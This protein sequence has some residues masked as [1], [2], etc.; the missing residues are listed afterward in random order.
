MGTAIKDTRVIITGGANGLGFMYSRHMLLKGA[1]AVAILDIDVATG[2]NAVKKLNDEFGQNRAVFISTD[3]SKDDQLKASFNKA[4]EHLGGLDIMINNAGIL[5]D[6]KWSL[7][8][9]INIKA[10]I[11][12]TYMAIETMGKHKGGKGGTIIN[13]GSVAAF[14]LTKY[15][16][17][18]CA[19]KSAVVSF[20]RSV[21]LSF[22]DVGVNIKAMCPG[23]TNTNLMT[24][25]AYRF[26]EYIDQEDGVKFMNAWPLQKPEIMAKEV[27]RFI[28]EAPNGAIW[29]NEIDSPTTC[30]DI[31]E[32]TSWKTPV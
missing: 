20:T 32:Y 31:P 1:K 17:V 3:V 13:I 8:I 7:M 19:T 22:D 27:M 24:S 15:V 10:L 16:P 4:V 9:D 14:L 11:Q 2:T 30:L 25:D 12:G 23:P 6:A 21:A 29:V 5:D 18:Y 28:E 26:P